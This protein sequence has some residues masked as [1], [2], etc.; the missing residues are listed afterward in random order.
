MAS[1]K[2]YWTAEKDA[3]IM[4][5]LNEEKSNAEIAARFPS[6]N[7]YNVKNRIQYVTKVHN[8]KHRQ[9]KATTELIKRIEPEI[10]SYL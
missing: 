6:R 1:D 7:F 3:L 10:K 5:L 8:L 9:K 2:V 4:Q